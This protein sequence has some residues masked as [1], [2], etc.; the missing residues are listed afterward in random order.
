LREAVE[1]KGELNEAVTGILEGNRA[2]PD[3][4]GFPFQEG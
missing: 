1:E 3:L 4:S 2:G